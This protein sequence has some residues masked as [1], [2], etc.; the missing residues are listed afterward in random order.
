MEMD[1]EQLSLM[2]GIV[3]MLVAGIG[4]L[5]YVSLVIAIPACRLLDWFFGAHD[6]VRVVHHPSFRPDRAAYLSTVVKRGLAR[7]RRPRWD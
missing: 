6:D 7:L 1:M 3:L 4:I 5:L 2:I